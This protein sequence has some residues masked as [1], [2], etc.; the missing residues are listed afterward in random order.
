MNT[1]N[2]GHTFKRYDGELD[3]LHYLVL[4]IG[5]LVPLTL[6]VKNAKGGSSTIDMKV[7]V[8]NAAPAAKP[9]VDHN[10]H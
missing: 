10:H 8:A 2:E 6:V 3:H 7:A 5:G 9:A 4:E 1:V